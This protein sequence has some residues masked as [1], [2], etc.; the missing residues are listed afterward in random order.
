MKHNIKTL[1]MVLTPAITS[2]LEKRIAHLDKFVNDGIA[3]TV[4][5]YVELGKTTKHHK[6]GDFFKTELTIHVGG[7]SFRAEAEESDLYASIDVAADE[8]MEE[9]KSFKDKKVSLIRRGG[10]K[11]KSFIKGFYNL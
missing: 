2:Y 3:E 5:C 10:S 6:K 9:L 7:K 1:D 4:M 11:L 8:M